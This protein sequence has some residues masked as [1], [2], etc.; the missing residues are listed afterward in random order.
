MNESDGSESAAQLQEINP[1]DSEQNHDSAN[2]SKHNIIF[3]AW[4]VHTFGVDTLRSGVVLDI[5]G[6]KGIL[7]FEL[8]VRYGIEA[9]VI[10][11]RMPAAHLN[12]LLNRKMK[13]NFPSRDT[14]KPVFFIFSTKQNKKNPKC[15]KFWMSR[16]IKCID[17]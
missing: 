7:A 13:K 14:T 5:G 12:G 11:T 17:G 9:T 10:D 8:T 6:G 15:L 3:A 2:S 16:C 1:D 4:L